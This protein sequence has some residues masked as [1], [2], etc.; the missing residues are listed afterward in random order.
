MDVEDVVDGT[1]RKE[2]RWPIAVALV[3]CRRCGSCVFCLEF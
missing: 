3:D 2:K 1:F